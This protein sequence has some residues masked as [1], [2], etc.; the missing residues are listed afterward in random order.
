MRPVAG[1]MLGQAALAENHFAKF[2]QQDDDRSA[3]SRSHFDRL[4]LVARLWICP[5]MP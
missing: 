4:G 2:F 3:V 1:G 5:S